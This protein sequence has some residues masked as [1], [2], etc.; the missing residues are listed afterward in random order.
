MGP[1]PVGTELAQLTNGKERERPRSTS[2][3]APEIDWTHLTGLRF[4]SLTHPWPESLAGVIEFVQSLV[5]GVFQPLGMYRNP[6]AVDLALHP[7]TDP[8]Y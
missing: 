6:G 3:S 7:L 5:D 8:L 2:L 1:S 4:F